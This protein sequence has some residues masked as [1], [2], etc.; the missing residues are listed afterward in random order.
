LILVASE[1][2]A[3]TERIVSYISDYGVP[4]N[5][6][7]FQHFRD[8]EREYL[9]RSWL[10]DPLEVNAP[11]ASQAARGAPLWKGQDFF[12]SFG[13]S[14]SLAHGRRRWED[15]VRSGFISAGGGSWF[16][17]TLDQLFAGARVFVHIP[18]L[19]YVGVGIV[20]ETSP[21]G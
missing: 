17:R 15:A 4:I 3:S 2:D 1:L 11:Q 5:V 19:G 18:K 10:I 8:G 20:R 16:S 14:D 13:E 6:V 7:F 12:V 21:A 9:A